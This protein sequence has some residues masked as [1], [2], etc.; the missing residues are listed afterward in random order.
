MW[1]GQCPTPKI[2]RRLTTN[3]KPQKLNLPATG[4]FQA[5]SSALLQNAEAGK[6]RNAL[7]S[8]EKRPKRP[9]G[10]VSNTVRHCSALS[11]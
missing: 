8:I 9:A 7:D 10:N 3:S 2:G 1:L 4:P 6:R 5:V 11:S